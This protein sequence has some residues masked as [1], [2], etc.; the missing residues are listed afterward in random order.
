MSVRPQ[1]LLLSLSHRFYLDDTYTT[2]FSRLS[3]TA[4]LKHAKTPPTALRLLS[5]N[6]FKAIILTDEG[7]TEHE[8]NHDQV[9]AQ[10]QEYMRDGAGLVIAAL[11]FPNFVTQDG[12][13]GFFGR[14]GVPWKKGDCHRMDFDVN[15]SCNRELLYGLGLATA[16]LPVRYSMKALGVRG[17]RVHEKVYLPIAGA[18]SQS[19][20]EA[21][22]SVDLSQAAVV[23]ARLG[24]GHLFYI[25]DVNWERGSQDAVVKLCCA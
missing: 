3:Q 12:F 24:R 4:T 17:A 10:V 11:H 2:L 15:P 6:T 1:I 14:L 16:D 20:I 9:L 8:P 23:G 5:Q 22:E 13:D 18:R 25:G 21:E 7:L 19:I